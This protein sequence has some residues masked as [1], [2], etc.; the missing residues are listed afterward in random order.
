MHRDELH[1]AEDYRHRQLEF[2]VATTGIVGDRQRRHP[3][4]RSEL[5]AWQLRELACK[6]APTTVSRRT[7]FRV[8]GPPPPACSPIKSIDPKQDRVLAAA[9]AQLRTCSH[10]GQFFYSLESQN[11]DA[12]V[13]PLED[14]VTTHRLGHCEYFAGAL[15]MMLRSQ[16]IPARMAI[17]FKGGEWNPLGMYYQVQQ[18]H[19]HAWVEVYLETADIPREDLGKDEPPPAAWLVLDPTDGV[20]EAGTVTRRLGLAA[21][22]NQYSDY[23]H[24][25]WSN[26]VVGLNTR[27]Q[28]Q[29]IYEPVAVVVGGTADA[30][31]QPI[32][33]A[34]RWRALLNSPVG[35]F[36]RWYRR[37]WFSWTRR[38]W[39]WLPARSVLRCTR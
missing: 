11:R 39:C 13:D 2:E 35:N 21:L 28:Q 4:V 6:C 25:L 38:W 16:G 29:E 3:A 9:R 31:A 8:C 5:G 24:V 10:S 30:V 14:F 1:A 20:Q 27:R 22:W 37:H 34:S 17:G 33:L 32:G 19:A 23:I 36:W 12:A 7:S 15:V 18:L 26:Y